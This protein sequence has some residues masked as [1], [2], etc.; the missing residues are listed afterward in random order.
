MIRLDDNDKNIPT[1][2]Q[3]HYDKRLG[4]G[5]VFLFLGAVFL[6][7]NIGLIPHTLKYYLFSWQ[8]ILIVIGLFLLAGNKNHKS[9]IVLIALGVLF[10][11]PG[12][13][14]FARIGLGQ[15]W[16]LVFVG[17]GI[18]ILIRH[19]NQSTEADAFIET[20]VSDQEDRIDDVNI[21]GG[22]NKIIRSKNFKGGRLTAI[23]GGADYN[24]TN[25][26]LAGNQVTIDVVTIFGG[27]KM[28][29]PADWDVVIDVVAI[30]G[31]F[32]DKR[33]TFHNIQFNSDKRLI[34]KGL[35][36]FGGGE[37]KNM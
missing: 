29:V 8:M 1:K 10:I 30:F 17:I 36:I 22:S 37:I 27:T 31:G 9:G 26:E 25:T 19:K 14:G 12:I 2:K 16:P 33:N 15:L 32:A 6:F 7:N 35:T 18:Y 11:I 34:I 24:F 23:F 13:L 28:V 5:I 21:F 4:I 3:E 20:S